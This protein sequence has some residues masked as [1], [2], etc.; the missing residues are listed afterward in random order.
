MKFAISK[1]YLIYEI[2]GSVKIH[3]QKRRGKYL[4][5]DTFK[6]RNY[7]NFII[8]YFDRYRLAVLR[9]LPNLEKLDDKVVSSEEIQIA[10]AIG[11]PLIHPLEVDASP[12]SDIVSPEVQTYFINNNNKKSMQ[13]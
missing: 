7:G 3:V 12:Q 8:H 10:M 2:C 5:V 9:A 6:M 13:Y 4:I 11:R 1:D